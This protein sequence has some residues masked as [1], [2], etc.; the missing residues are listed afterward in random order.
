MRFSFVILHYK[1]GSLF[2][3][4]E[5]VDSIIKLKHSSEVRIIIVDNG[6][7]DNSFI[8]LMKKYEG[9]DY[10]EVILNQKNLGFANGNNSGYQFALE[11]YKP[12]FLVVMNNDTV[13]LQ[14]DFLSRVINEFDR[15]KFHFLG[16]KILD[17]KS[18]SQSPMYNSLV[19]IKD[20][21]KELEKKE[22]EL[23]EIN[24]NSSKYVLKKTFN[25]FL[26]NIPFIGDI[27]IFL[28]RFILQINFTSLYTTSI[29][30]FIVKGGRQENVMIHGSIVIFSKLYIKEYSYAFYPETFMYLEENILHY[31]ARRD[32]LK[33]VFNPD[34]LVFHKE[35]VSTNL[36]YTGLTKRKFQLEN[37]IISLEA[38][39]K[40]IET[41][42]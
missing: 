9:Y 33:I 18:K 8:L 35:D 19:T 14:D 1:E 37:T 41:N 38:F 39:K 29:R 11:N 21:V 3:T 4:Y 34:I 12:D 17:K 28:K 5:C 25:V 22:K 6:S 2:D 32:G 7:N 16:P 30:D 23:H 15:S 13:I 31:I 24:H 20:V 10:V 42:S 26:K 27:L 36:D 40:L